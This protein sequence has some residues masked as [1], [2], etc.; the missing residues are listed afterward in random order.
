MTFL[1]L[2]LD[3]DLLD[4]T[5]EFDLERRLFTGD[6]DLFTGDLDF[7]FLCL[8]GEGERFFSSGDCSAEEDRLLEVCFLGD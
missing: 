7:C 3:R 5:G 6:L 8:L 4:L 1:S 2:D